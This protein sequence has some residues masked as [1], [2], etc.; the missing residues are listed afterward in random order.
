MVDILWEEFCL[1]LSH[2]EN[3]QLLML[4]MQQICSPGQV[5]NVCNDALDVSFLLLGHK[6]YRECLNALGHVQVANNLLIAKKDM[7][8]AGLDVLTGKLV[9]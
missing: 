7:S 3:E 8:A 1:S 2:L 4:I 5:R 6:L 9:G